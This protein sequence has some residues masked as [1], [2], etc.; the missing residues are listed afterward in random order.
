MTKTM[1]GCQSRAFLDR[2]DKKLARG[3]KEDAMDT[4]R[5][6]LGAGECVE[7]NKGDKVTIVG[8]GIGLYRVQPD[9][10]ET[11]YWTGAEVLGP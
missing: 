8:A 4:L 7:L 6:A 10:H 11:S 9:G 2:F 3:E 1:F 5:Q